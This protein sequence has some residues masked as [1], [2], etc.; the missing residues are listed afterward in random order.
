M[1]TIKIRLGH[2]G[3]FAIID[4]CDAY[5]AQ[6]K[7]QLWKR[8]YTSYAV[9]IVRHHSKFHHRVFMHRQIMNSQPGT[10]VDHIDCDGLNNRRTNLRPATKGENARNLPKRNLNSTSQFKGVYWDGRRN[11]W[12]AA[13]RFNNKN[14]HIGRFKI[15]LDAAK[16]YDMAAIRLHESFARTNFQVSNYSIPSQ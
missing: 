15:E 11:L 10:F 12:T 3:L 13:I 9:R 5:L 2:S 14:H 1:E 4:R 8:R 16:A 6:W 7:W